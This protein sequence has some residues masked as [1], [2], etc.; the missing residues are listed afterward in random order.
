MQ[1]ARESLDSTKTRATTITGN[2][3]KYQS[4]LEE[5]KYAM[6]ANRSHNRVL[7]FVMQLKAKGKTPGIFGR[8]VSIAFL[9]RI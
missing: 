8:L 3:R 4:Q 9:F 5:K 6:K 2:L 7:D 1:K